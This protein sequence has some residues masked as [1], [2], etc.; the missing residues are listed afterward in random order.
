M[1]ARRKD[2]IMNPIFHTSSRS[3]L[4]LA[5][6]CIYDRQLFDENVGNEVV[7]MF[8]LDS[9]L[10][11]QLHRLVECERDLTH[12]ILTYVTTRP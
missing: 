5:L 9:E 3:D 6:D 12:A 2:L 1:D 11:N 4:E 10:Q 8:Y 7:I